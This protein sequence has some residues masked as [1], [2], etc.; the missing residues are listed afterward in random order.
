[1][2]TKNLTCIECPRGCSLTVTV[3]GDNIT[4]TG[5]TCKRGE[6]YGKNEV[7]CPKRYVTSTVRVGG[8]ML[9][10]R[11]DRAIDKKDIFEVMTAINTAKVNG[12]YVIGNVIIPN[13]D[14]KGANIIATK[15]TKTL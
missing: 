5:N 12:D 11:T 6:E 13:V 8:M 14:G 10:V 7:T 1:M 9:P 3:D 15:N 4:V 2:E